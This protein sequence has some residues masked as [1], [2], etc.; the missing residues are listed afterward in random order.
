MSNAIVLACGNP[1]R[2]DDGVAVQVAR[3]LEASQSDPQTE[4]LCAQQWT[5]EF[6]ERISHAELAVFVDASVDI[7]PGKIQLQ[8][9]HASG[10]QPRVRTQS[11]SP[12]QLLLLAKQTY[13]RAP[14]QAFLVRIGAAS[15]AHGRDLTTPVRQAIPKALEQIKSLLSGAPLTSTPNSP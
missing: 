13:G 14:A 11:M 15:F 3:R 4:I 5:A 1:L 12:E 8:E 2:G 10:E 6:A 9:V 7:S